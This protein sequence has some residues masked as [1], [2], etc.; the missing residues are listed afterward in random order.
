M[1]AILT[2][3]S[4][5]ITMPTDTLIERRLCAVENALLDLQRQ[6]Q[7]QAPAGNWLDRFKGAFKGEPAF[8]EVVRYGR[9]IRESDRLEEDIVK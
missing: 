1:A 2:S 8:D 4:E 6:L 7:I 5:S 3:G 9:E